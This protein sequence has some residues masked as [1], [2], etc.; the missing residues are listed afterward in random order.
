LS[1]LS[2]PFSLIVARRV[3]VKVQVERETA[4]GL[5]KRQRAAFKSSKAKQ[6]T[7]DFLGVDQRVQSSLHPLPGHRDG[8]EFSL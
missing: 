2:D 4:H 5:V 3:G 8:V 1:P 7:F 6:A